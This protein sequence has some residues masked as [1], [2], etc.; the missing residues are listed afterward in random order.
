MPGALDVL[1]S[2][3]FVASFM[4]ILMTLAHIASREYGWW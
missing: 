1:E 4:F 2:M 3:K